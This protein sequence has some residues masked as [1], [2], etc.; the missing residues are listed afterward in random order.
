MLC[1][2][3]AD[4]GRANGLGEARPWMAGL[5]SG[6]LL[7]SD[8]GCCRTENTKVLLRAMFAHCGCATYKSWRCAWG[9]GWSV[10]KEYGGLAPVWV[11][12]RPKARA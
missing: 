6:V 3:I 12:G 9:V 10:K 8:D 4:A 7:P 2:L 11:M 1:M 5:G